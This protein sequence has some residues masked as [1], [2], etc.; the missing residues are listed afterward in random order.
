MKR[1][2][3]FCLS[4]ATVQDSADGLSFRSFEC[5]NSIWAANLALIK[6][7]LR[8]GRLM[9]NGLELRVLQS[10]AVKSIH[11]GFAVE[12]MAGMQCL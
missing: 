6:A 2:L 7:N 9:L 12:D 4:E 11:D 10:V 3:W 8:G 5:N 1:C